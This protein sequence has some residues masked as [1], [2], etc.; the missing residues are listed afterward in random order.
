M[1]S[2]KIP[3]VIAACDSVGAGGRFTITKK[4]YVVLNV[5]EPF[6]KTFTVMMF[7]LGDCAM[8]G[9]HEKK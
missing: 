6:I 1:S 8:V 5:G 9:R 2:E 7:V 3:F 4:L